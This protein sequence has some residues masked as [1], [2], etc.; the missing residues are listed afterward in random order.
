MATVVH[1]TCNAVTEDNDARTDVKYETPVKNGAQLLS[2]PDVPLYL[3]F[4]RYIFTGYRPQMSWYECLKSLFY[5]HNETLNILTH[6]IPL[7][8]LVL[9]IPAMLPWHQITI[10]VLPY[11]HVLATISP[12]LGSFIYHVFMN[13][14]KGENLYYCLL[15]L[16]MFGIWVTQSLGALT[17]VS[18]S[19]FCLGAFLRYCILASYTFL[20]AIALYKALVAADPW[21]RRLSFTLQFCFRIV[22]FCIRL[23]PFGGGDPASIAHVFLQDFLSVIGGAIGATQVPERW[24]P[25]RVD[26]VGNSHH[27]MHVLVVIAIVHMHIAAR[28]DLLWMSSNYCT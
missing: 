22:L 23:S 24:L 3:Q 2:L 27:I 9:S 16:D 6:G 1:R 12:W 21:Q 13:H 17:T 25:G 19:T 20:S 15:R 26:S 7:V 8:F 11:T 4:N 10:P 18:A 28:N 5:W 14:H